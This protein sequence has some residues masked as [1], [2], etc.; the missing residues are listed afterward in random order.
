MYRKNVVA[1][2]SFL[3]SKRNSLLAESQDCQNADILL[4]HS[5]LE[6]MFI[7]FMSE[8]NV[9]CPQELI[10]LEKVLGL[11]LRNDVQN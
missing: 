9:K 11:F 1:G 10:L 2:L 5:M 8:N 7:C 3:V 4:F 6:Y